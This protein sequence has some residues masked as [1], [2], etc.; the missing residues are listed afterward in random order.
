[1][2]LLQGRTRKGIEFK[3]KLIFKLDLFE[4]IGYF[5]K[6]IGEE[7]VS[8]LSVALTLQAI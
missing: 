3:N 5:P 1:M 6:L 4:P 8:F 2:C 7:T